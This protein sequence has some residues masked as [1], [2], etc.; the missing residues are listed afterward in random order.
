MMASIQVGRGRRP[1]V[2]N[3]RVPIID[4]VFLWSLVVWLFFRLTD[5]WAD[6][7]LH[8]L[9]R[10]GRNECIRPTHWRRRLVRLLS[11]F[12]LHSFLCCHWRHWKTVWTESIVLTHLIDSVRVHIRWCTATWLLRSCFLRLDLSQCLGRQLAHWIINWVYCGCI[13]APGWNLFSKWWSSWSASR[14]WL[15]RVQ[16]AL[17]CRRSSN[18]SIECWS[19]SYCSSI[20]FRFSLNDNLFVLDS[21]EFASL[22]STLL[23]RFCG[24]L[25]DHY[26]FLF[27]FLVHHV[28]L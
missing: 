10:F 15:L 17:F 9:F 7:L 16:D 21:L 27:R 12:L 24:N 1:R 8:L 22:R 18:G 3:N 11:R 14:R 28:F 25:L 2:I 19:S 13:I 23:D 26:F 20:D 6:Q 5:T 4:L